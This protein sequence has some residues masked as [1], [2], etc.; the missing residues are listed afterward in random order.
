[1]IQHT[2]ILT[3]PKIAIPTTNIIEFTKELISANQTNIDYFGVELDNGDDYVDSEMQ[4]KLD[5]ST[6]LTFHFTADAIDYIIPNE[7]N[8]INLLFKLLN[9]NEIGQIIIDEKDIEIY[10]NEGLLS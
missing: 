7:D 4:S 3:T 5:N 8:T 1:M 6:F 2:I 10:I 9:N